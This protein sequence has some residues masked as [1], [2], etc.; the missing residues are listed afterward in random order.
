M[1]M[2]V[3]CFNMIWLNFE[4][5]IHDIYP[6]PLL[7]SPSLRNVRFGGSFLRRAEVDDAELD[8]ALSLKLVDIEPEEEVQQ[9]A[10]GRNSR[11]LPE[12]D[13]LQ[14]AVVSVCDLEP[15]VRFI[16]ADELRGFDADSAEEEERFA[17]PGPER[18]ERADLRD[19]FFVAV[20][21]FQLGFDV[22]HRPK[23]FPTEALFGVQRQ[24]FPERVPICR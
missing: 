17:V 3:I 2:N 1:S 11:T 22:F 10:D 18:F 9:R 5:K 21:G 24:P 23:V 4:R 20:C 19:G 8:R 16:F 13:R 6:I 12:G 15:Q 7:L 14:R